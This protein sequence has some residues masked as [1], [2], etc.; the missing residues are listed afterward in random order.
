MS[1]T[2]YPCL[3][4]WAILFLRRFDHSASP[5]TVVRWGND[6]IFTFR[7]V[8]GWSRPHELDLNRLLEVDKGISD[9]YGFWRGI[10]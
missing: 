10:S 6:W 8:V 7:T 3:R 2:C 4:K 5:A 1:A 9:I